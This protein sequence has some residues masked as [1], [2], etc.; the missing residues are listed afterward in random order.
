[1]WL[2]PAS[3]L[4]LFAENRIKTAELVVQNPDKNIQ[5]TQVHIH[6]DRAI[7]QNTAN[8]KYHVKVAKTKEIS[9]LLEEGF[10]YVLQKDDLIYFRKGKRREFNRCNRKLWYY[11][12]SPNDGDV[13]RISPFFSVFRDATYIMD[14]LVCIVSAAIKFSAV[15]P[16]QA[17]KFNV[18]RSIDR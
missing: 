10:E 9:Q 17:K 6:I 14:A 2:E 13:S 5:N 18:D 1:M 15:T 8:D 3:I 11:F 12:A 16:L 4:W 7:F